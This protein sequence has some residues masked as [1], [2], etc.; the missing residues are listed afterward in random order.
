MAGRSLHHEAFTRSLVI[1]PAGVDC[2]ATAAQM[3]VIGVDPRQ[4]SVAAA[5]FRARG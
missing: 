5:G 1:C 3:L 4:V 2:S